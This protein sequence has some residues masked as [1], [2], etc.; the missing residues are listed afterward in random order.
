MLL[1]LGNELCLQLHHGIFDARA[2]KILDLPLRL[3][4]R[5]IVESPIV[6]CPAPSSLHVER[7]R[8]V[9]VRG[10]L[11]E[12]GLVAEGAL[13]HLAVVAFV[14]LR[15]GC[16]QAGL[17]WALPTVQ[18]RCHGARRCGVACVLL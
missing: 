17:S 11:M 16:D 1:V 2:R 15:V 5:R 18:M 8:I 6:S 7:H 10:A 13:A 4:R 12:V 14:C 3:R 9:P